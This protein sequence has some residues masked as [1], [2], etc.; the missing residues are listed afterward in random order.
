MQIGDVQ[1]GIEQSLAN[2]KTSALPPA[3]E[4]LRH[5]PLG[6]HEPR[7][8]IRGRDGG[9]RVRKDADA[10][11]FDPESCEVVIRFFP[12]ET[13]T[14]EDDRHEANALRFDGQA[15]TFDFKTATGELLDELRKVEGTRPFVSLKWFRDHILPECGHDWARDSRIKHALLRHAT[16]QRLILTSQVPNPHQPHHPVTAIR[17]NRRHPRFQTDAPRRGAGFTPVRIRGGSI[18]DTILGDRR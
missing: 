8:S 14:D 15:D 1:L 16:E 7:V 18:S 6:G 4:G 3:L 5:L 11:Y 2:L 13:A 10:S 9:R 12:F 17:I